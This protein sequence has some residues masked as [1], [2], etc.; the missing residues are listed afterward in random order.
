MR[1]SLA[2][3]ADAKEI[4]G[5]FLEEAGKLTKEA[6]DSLFAGLTQTWKKK[7]VYMA[8]RHA[9]TAKKDGPE[10]I[11]LVN[12]LGWQEVGERVRSAIGVIN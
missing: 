6:D 9:L 5:R 8:V 3:I 10:L 1:K 11:A 7:D 12:I 4:L 2:G